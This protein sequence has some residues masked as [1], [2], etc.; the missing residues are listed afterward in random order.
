MNKLV[1][2]YVFFLGISFASS[3]EKELNTTPASLEKNGDLKAEY[4]PKLLAEALKGTN[5]SDF[6]N[7]NCLTA[8]KKETKGSFNTL[9]LFVIENTCKKDNPKFIIKEARDSIKE[10]TNLKNIENF[11]NIKNT[12]YYNEQYFPALTLPIA[13]LG[14]NADSVK[15]NLLLMSFAKGKVFCDF[16]K[17]F[18]DNQTIE[19][20]KRIETAYYNFGKALSN[21]HKR[22]MTKMSGSKSL[23][24]NTVNHGDLHC[25]NIYYNEDNNQFT[26]IDNETM[27]LTINNKQSPSDDIL[28][29]F[30]GLL[31]QSEPTERKDMISGIETKKF[32]DLALTSFL[33]GYIETYEKDKKNQLIKELKNIF[34]SESNFPWKN[35][36]KAE[37]TEIKNKYVIPVF[38]R[39]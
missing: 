11:I 14:Y 34:I 15:H 21:F 13:Y 29:P 24:N 20:A 28:K 31:S 9:Q 10:E 3:I 16:V 2:L 33:K 4:L 6:A 26:F 32:F 37:F 36:S 22:F 17:E 18:R 23:I 19:N 12:N 7:N 38:M 39:L 1:C 8:Q 27:A 35:I 25:Y 5:L 30:Y